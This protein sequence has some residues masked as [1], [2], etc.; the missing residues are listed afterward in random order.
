MVIEKTVCNRLQW[1]P[2][3]STWWWLPHHL[4]WRF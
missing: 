3:K 2:T 1:A 4:L